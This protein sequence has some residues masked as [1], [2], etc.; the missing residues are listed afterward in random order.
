[1]SVRSS[2]FE[3]SSVSLQSV[4][5]LVDEVVMS[6]QY[7]ADTTPLLGG[8]APSYHVVSQ[9]IQPLVEEVVV[10]IQ[11]SID[12][13]LLLESVDS[14]KVVTLMQSSVDP[15]LPLESVK[16]TKVVTPMQYL[17]D[18]TL[19]MGSDVSTDY[20]FSISI[21]VLSKQGGIPLTLSTPPPSPRMVLFDWNDLC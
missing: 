3:S 21:S 20:V 1:M 14:T 5:P 8:N 12:P 18:P 16:S 11:S 2:N 4:H 9:P 15:T 13:T 7:S 19:I 17:V 10:P 6:M